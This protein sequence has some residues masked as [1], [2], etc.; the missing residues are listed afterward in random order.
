MLKYCTSYTSVY[1]RDVGI[2]QPYDQVP[3][4][5]IRVD[6][7]ILVTTRCLMCQDELK[8]GGICEFDTMTQS[9]LCLC[10]NGNSITHR[11]DKGI[12]QHNRKVHV[13]AGTV[14]SF[15]AAGAFGIGA[16]IWYLKKLRKT[17]SVTF[18]V[19]SNENRL[20]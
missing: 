13:I 10:K 4:Y 8:G 19:R 14:T 20:F 1:W 6:F 11:K 15:S 16:G 12:A 17:S 18:G 7:D 9:F 2:P 3:E 5:G